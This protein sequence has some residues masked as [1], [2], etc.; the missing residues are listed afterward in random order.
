MR[1]IAD[2]YGEIVAYKDSQSP[3]ADLAP[4]ADTE[5]QLLTDLNSSSKVAIWRLLAYIIAVAIW[6]HESLW[7][8]FRTEVQAIA[9][10]AIVG[11]VRWYQDQVFKFQTGYTLSYDSA[12]GKYVYSVIDTGAQIVKRCAIIEGQDGVLA[13]KVAKLA[14]GLP[15]SL[16][17][18]E[19]DELA[20]YLKK[21]RFAGTKFTVLSGNGDILRVAATIYYDGVIPL[22]T[23]T[24]NVK[25]AINAFIGALP[26]NGKFLLSA[27]TDHIQA[28]TGVEDVVLDSVETKTTGGDPYAPIIRIH[29]PLYGYYKIDVTAGN[30]LDDTL[31]FIAQ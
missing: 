14:S 21:V 16:S 29:V 17:G 6:T 9:D 11:T 19:V 25:A 5:Q 20:L 3:I 26:F 15:T 24:D 28:V 27:L 8:I 13:F 7:E 30:T 18:G 1:T 12:T 10:A 31:N 4:T 2:I 22:A 23:I